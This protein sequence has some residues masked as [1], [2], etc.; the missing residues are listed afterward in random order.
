MG[1]TVNMPKLKLKTFASVG[2]NAMMTK[3]ATYLIGG[4]SLVSHQ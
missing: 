4:S 2:R 1:I 3:E